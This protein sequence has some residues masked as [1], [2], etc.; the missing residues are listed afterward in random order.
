MTLSNKSANN[1]SV[2]YRLARKVHILEL[3]SAQVHLMSFHHRAQ[4]PVYLEFLH[5]GVSW[6]ARSTIP[7]RIEDLFAQDE[8]CRVVKVERH[9]VDVPAG[10]LAMPK[11]PLCSLPNFSQI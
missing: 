4:K 11:G 1:H 8:T 5:S 2:I 9:L 10:C 7:L 3:G 6:T